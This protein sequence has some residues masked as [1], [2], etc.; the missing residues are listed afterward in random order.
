MP[1]SLTDALALWTPERWQRLPA[2]P[3]WK[4]Y[5]TYVGSRKTPPQIQHLMT[6]L[7][8]VGFSRGYRLRS[9]HAEGADL[10][11]ELGIVQHPHYQLRDTPFDTD[12][13]VILPW[14]GFEPYPGYGRATRDRGFTEAAG[15]YRPHE[16]PLWSQAKTM[17][18]GLH[19]LGE[20][21]KL[22]KYRATWDLHARNMFQP[23]GLNLDT[24]SHRTYL[25]APPTADGLCKGGTRS[26][27]ALSHRLNIPTINLALDFQLNRLVDFLTTYALS[28]T[29]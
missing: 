24:P 26:A 17:A 13:Y 5:I 28:L 4:G 7:A 18:M 2:P 6:V 12:M 16:M 20:R 27:M 23:L 25:W 3:A 19:P 9:G 11:S 1:H 22:P 14:D 21:L 29:P 15:Y 8:A 10:A